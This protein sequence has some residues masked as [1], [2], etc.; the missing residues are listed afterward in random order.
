M[1]AYQYDRVHAHDNLYV[2][3][4]DGGG[5][6]TL[7]IDVGTQ[8]VSLSLVPGSWSNSGGGATT[9]DN[10]EPYDNLWLADS[11]VI[12][13]L[14][15]GAGDDIVYD[16]EGGQ[17]ISLG[18]G[19][20]TLVY[21]GGDDAVDGGAGHDIARLDAQPT[22]FQ[23]SVNGDQLSVKELTSGDLL[24][25]TGIEELAFA[26]DT[27]LSSSAAASE[28]SE[29]NVGLLVDE[30]V[31]AWQSPIVAA[32]GG[33]IGAEEARLYRIY[34]GAMNR[35][36]DEG[37]YDWWLER[38]QNDTFQF[39]EVADR[40]IDSPEFKQLADA[41]Q[42]GTIEDTEF[43]DHVY[44]TVFGRAP[45][46]DGYN[47]WLQQLDSAVYSQG[48]AFASMTQSD[49][50]VLLSAGAVSDFWLWGE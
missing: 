6:N 34:Y 22:R 17:Q 37:G 7:V 19:A 30:G 15:L 2:G 8:A 1:N 24:V 5:Y 27:V 36:P 42:D 4:A 26:D 3:I 23:F 9:T 10:P 39:D 33:E 11:A 18:D 21:V 31:A 32:A 29:L 50:F 46:E 44:N 41:D 43:L 49:E 45:D 14:V 16:S 38:V 48:E 47:W 28:L 35:A 40:F 13:Q 12:H 25:L 20:D